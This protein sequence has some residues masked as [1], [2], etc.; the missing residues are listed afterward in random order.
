M[1]QG[2]LVTFIVLYT[3]GILKLQCK[4]ATAVLF[5][6]WMF[7]PRLECCTLV[8]PSAHLQPDLQPL[9]RTGESE[10]TLDLSP[11]SD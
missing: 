2:L 4:G 5:L 7:N 11:P 1:I 8:S 3:L 9:P 10:S 6:V